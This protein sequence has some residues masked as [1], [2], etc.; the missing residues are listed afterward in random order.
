M[1]TGKTHSAARRRKKKRQQ[2]MRRR[3]IFFGCAAAV[4]ILAVV[5][6]TSRSSGRDRPADN[7]DALSVITQAPAEAES[8]ADAP[9]QAPAANASVMANGK[10]AY[11]ELP[12]TAAVDDS[13]FDDAVFVGDSVMQGFRY[14]VK[15][16]RET[17]DKGYFGEAQFL[18]AQSYALYHAISSSEKTQH[19]SYRGKVQ[20]VEISIRDMGAKKVYIM[21]GMNDIFLMGVMKSL[22]NYETLIGRI[23]EKAPDVEIYIL[24]VIP[25]TRNAI[26]K[27]SKMDIGA[28][29]F[30]NQRLPQFAQEHECYFVDVS[31]KYLDED[32]Y[33][34]SE[35]SSDDYVH[36]QSGCFD[37]WAE[38]LKT[39]T[40][41]PH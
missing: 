10:Y 16:Q 11:G 24:S 33:L 40:A 18:T 7:W 3:A 20:P 32:G 6:I 17:R 37:F 35:Y 9:T 36:I 27:N 13:Y 8:V 2:M 26:K 38:A 14:D 12:E 39:H 15:Y 1:A 21:L 23:R 31:K 30:F 22:T 25:C 29:T 19:P 28:Y 4:V 34:K 5:L 41:V